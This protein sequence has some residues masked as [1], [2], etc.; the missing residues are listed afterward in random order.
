MINSLGK[1]PQKWQHFNV[2]FG[3]GHVSSDG[4]MVSA[5]WVVGAACPMA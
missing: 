3:M 5:F 4:G 2:A 1:V